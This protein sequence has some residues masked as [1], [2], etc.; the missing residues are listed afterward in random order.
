MS[1]PRQRA[2][3]SSQVSIPRLETVRGLEAE[4]LNSEN[5]GPLRLQLVSDSHEPPQQRR[6]GSDSA[7]GLRNAAVQKTPGLQAETHQPLSWPYCQERSRPDS[8]ARARATVSRKDR[9]R[10]SRREEEEGVDTSERG[11]RGGRGRDV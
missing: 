3:I 8:K 11:R 4:T 1:Q 2:P 7:R 10:Q 6:H 9:T 5:P